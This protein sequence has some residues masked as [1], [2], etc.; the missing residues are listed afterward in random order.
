M[1]RGR[2]R[3][4]EE[5]GGEAAGWLTGVVGVLAVGVAAGALA[6]VVEDA[7]GVAAVAAVFVTD[8][9]AVVTGAVACVAGAVAPDTAWPRPDAALATP[10]PTISIAA[11]ITTRPAKYFAPLLGLINTP[12]EPRIR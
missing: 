3:G 10:P 12:I 11:R 2:R 9:A 7:A 4:G 5:V 1:K 8:P 6:V